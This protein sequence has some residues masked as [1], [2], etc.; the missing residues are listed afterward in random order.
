MNVTQFASLVVVLCLAAPP[1]LACLNDEETPRYEEDFQKQYQPE[2]EYRPGQPV[3]WHLAG[4][5]LGGALAGSAVVIA[6]RQGTD[7]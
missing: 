2:P 7:A 6:A 1:G 4:L 3:P 5:G